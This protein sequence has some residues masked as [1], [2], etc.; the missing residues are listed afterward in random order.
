MFE[1]IREKF[2]EDIEHCKKCMNEIDK[3]KDP[4]SW[5]HWYSRYLYICGL[6]EY[7]FL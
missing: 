7:L 6:V 5:Q 1:R 2:A 4:V 3:E